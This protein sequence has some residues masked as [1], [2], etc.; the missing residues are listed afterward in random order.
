MKLLTTVVASSSGVGSGGSVGAVAV[1][2]APPRTNAKDVPFGAHS[3]EWKV[4]LASR[5]RFE[6][7]GRPWKMSVSPPIRIASWLDQLASPAG[8]VACVAPC[9]LAIRP[10]SVVAYDS[11]DAPV[12]QLCNTAVCRTKPTLFSGLQSSEIKF[13]SC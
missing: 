5:P 2:S 8:S 4:P 9:V 12:D 6:A 11:N 3:G 7:S 13:L 1:Q 10:F